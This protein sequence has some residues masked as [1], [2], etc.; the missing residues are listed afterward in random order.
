[1]HKPHKPA[2]RFKEFTNDWQRRRLDEVVQITMGHS[3]DGKTYSNKPSKYILV[4]GNADLCDG[5]VFPRIW[6]TQETKKAFEGELIMSVRAPAGAIGKTSYEVVIGRGVAA[7]KGNEFIYQ[8]LSNKYNNGY[9]NNMSSGSTFSS[10]NSGDIKSASFHFPIEIEQ[11]KIGYMFSEIDTL[12]T[13]QKRKLEKLKNIKNMLL[14]KMFADEKTLKPA[15]R[16]KEFTNA[17]E[18]RRLGDEV[19]NCKS[20]IEIDE[21]YPDGKFDLYGVNGFIG[22]T[23]KIIIKDKWL[24]GIVKDGSV[25]KVFLLP[26]NSSFSS[27]IEGLFGKND[28]LTKFIFWIIKRMDL[29]KYFIGSTIKHL[30]FK[31]YKQSTILIPSIHEQNKIVSSF[32][33]IDSLITLHQRK[34]EKLKNIKNMLL[35]KMFI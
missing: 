34:L 15:I 27:T 21:I 30:Y 3:P 16:F 29:S 12:I 20:D 1:M 28:K 26:P 9:W 17:W 22:K 13:L 5:W 19:L 7:I 32:S 8:L 35:E 11:N 31:Q 6:T 4:Q 14:E 33:L 25:G 23:N 18:Q 2:I 10:L 24:I